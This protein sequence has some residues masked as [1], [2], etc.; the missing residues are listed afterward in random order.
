MFVAYLTVV[1]LTIL[2]NAGIAFADFA[3]AKFVLANGAEV[4]VPASWLPALAALK[5][6]GAAGLLLGLLGATAIAV[7]AATGLTAFYIGAVVA[8]VRARVFYNIAF[9]GAYLALAAGSLTLTI[10]R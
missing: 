4:G 10:V 1:I 7:A 5:L 8:H 3:K 9:P 2:A 6:A